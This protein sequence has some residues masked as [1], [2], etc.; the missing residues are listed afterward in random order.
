MY[1]IYCTVTV[2]SRLSKG[3]VIMLLKSV[4]IVS[5]VLLLTPVYAGAGDNSPEKKEPVS[6]VTWKTEARAANFAYNHLVHLTNDCKIKV[7]CKVKTDAAPD[8]VK[9]LLAPGGKKTVLTFRSSP[10][11][12]FTAS[13]NCFK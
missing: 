2:N 3:Y 1:Y 12:K 11:R 4:I 9:V 7:T 8:P 5:L 6:C 13:V 10:A